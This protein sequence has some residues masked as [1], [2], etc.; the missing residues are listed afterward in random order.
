MANWIVIGEGPDHRLF[1]L[2][3]AEQDTSEIFEHFLA[4]PQQ[5]PQQV[6]S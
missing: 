6:R 5:R 2:L 3:Q 1:V 4:P